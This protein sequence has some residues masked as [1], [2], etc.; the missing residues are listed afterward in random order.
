MVQVVA[1]LGW[2]LAGRRGAL[3]ASAGFLLPSMALMVAGAAVL[4]SL[5]A[6]PAIGGALL[7]VQVAVVGLLAVALRRLAADVP[8]GPMRLLSVVALAAGLLAVNAALVVV[9]GGLLAM[10]LRRD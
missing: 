9:A 3:A 7:G 6:G 10:V 1:F 8:W 5:P 4:T 2:R